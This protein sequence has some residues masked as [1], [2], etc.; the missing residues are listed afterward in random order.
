M[1][2]I[3]S[4]FALQDE[5]GWIAREQILGAEAR[6]RVPR[7]FRPQHRDHANPPTLCLAVDALLRRVQRAE[8]CA[9]D[10]SKH[11]GPCTSD[12]MNVERT[13]HFLAWVYPRMQRHYAWLRRTQH[14]QV[15]RSHA[16]LARAAHVYRWRGR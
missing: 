14:G 5:D 10:A 3:R 9:R 16:G 6:N 1:E 7:E 15:P 2:I 12:D 11:A 13:R 4:W 8:A